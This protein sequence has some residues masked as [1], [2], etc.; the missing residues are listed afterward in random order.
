MQ[1]PWTLVT[2]A[3]GF[4][5]SRLVRALVERGERVKAFV[6]AGSNLSM[7]EG[8]PRDRFELAFGDVMVEHTVYRG[9]ASCHRM[10]HVAAVYKLWDK[11]A[12]RIT[13]PTIEGMRSTL[14]AAKKRGLEKVVITSSYA[15]LGASASAESRDEGAEFNFADPNPYIAAKYEA[16]QIALEMIDA[17]LPGVVVL[18][19]GT[20]GPGDWKPTPTGAYILRY[21]TSSPAFRYPITDGGLNL[22]DVDDVVSGH[23]AAMNQGKIGQRY[24]LGGENL[25][26]EQVIEILSELTGL[27]PPGSKLST[28]VVVFAAE[29]M[30]LKARL[31]GGE[32]LI[33]PAVARDVLGRYQWVVS[34]K[35][36]RAL[37]YTHRPAREALDRA[38]RWYLSRGYVPERA[39]RR[40]RLELR[41]I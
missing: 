13:R 32:P 10:Y 39:A 25:T 21:L 23:I 3:S 19:S 37:G 31:F 35:A 15:T 7:L 11:R 6:R 5:G 18:P 30:A 28:G 14:R 9:L 8:L 17:G 4:I 26:Y 34:K 22:V 12:E 41:P 2:G 16:E 33:A 38:V 24:I 20:T 36:E 40:V 29:L 27:A 1:Q